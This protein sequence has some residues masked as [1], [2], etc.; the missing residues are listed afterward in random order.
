VPTSPQEAG[1]SR[2]WR[3]ITL[4]LLSFLA[5]AARAADDDDAS[6]STAVGMNGAALPRLQ[7]ANGVLYLEVSLNGQSTHNLVSF[8]DRAGHLLVQQRDLTALGIEPTAANLHLAAVAPEV[9]PGHGSAATEGD[10]MLDLNKM[11]GVRYQLDRSHQTID[12][13]VSDEQRTPYALGGHS[14]TV[15]PARSGTGVVFNYDVLAQTSALDGPA[16]ASLSM[17]SEQ[18]LFT[19]IGVLSNFGLATWNGQSQLSGT[20]NH[21]TRE[22]TTFE[23]QN[24]ASLQTADLGDVVSGALGWTRSV[25]LGGFQVRSDYSLDP[26]MIT[27]PVPRFNGSAALPSTV[28]LYVNNVRQYSGSVPGGPFVV[29]GGLGITGAGTATVVVHD[30]FGR[31]VSTTMPIYVDNRLLAPGLN[32]YSVESGVLRFNYGLESFGYEGPPA[33]SGTFRRGLSDVV[34]IESHGE[35]TSRLVDGGGGALFRLGSSGVLHVAAAGSTSEGHGGSQYL[36]G[37]Q[38]ILP[39]FSFTAQSI[40]ATSGYRDLATFG[41]TPAPRALDQVTAS[42]VTGRDSTLGASYVHLSDSVQRNS[43]IVALYYSN[44]LSHRANAFVNVSDDLA[45]SHSAALFVGFSYDM[46]RRVSSAL[47]F[48]MNNGRATYGASAVRNVDYGGGLEWTLQANRNVGQT[49]GAGRVGYLGEYGEISGIAQNVAGHTQLSIEDVGGLVFMDGTFEASRRV[50]D[51]FALVSTGGVA[52]VPVLHENRP[53]GTT[54]SGGHF[55]VPDL[56]P[57]THNSLSIDSL[58]LA[59][60]VSVPM[61]SM[62]VTPRGNSGVLADFHIGHYQAASITLVNS[63][64]KPLPAGTVAHVA[65]SG[66]DFVVGYDGLA[67]IEE[68]RPENHLQVRTPEAQCSAQFSFNP[69]ASTALAN[70]GKVVC[71]PAGAHPI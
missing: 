15:P 9:P 50:G 27:F 35:V 38:V 54:D 49:S 32:S 26:Q 68:L 13:Q 69:T 67:F 28:D 40:R 65:E 10:R 36:L 19:P 61:A 16:R 52:G 59:A 2:A 23:Y 58:T 62:D 18:R 46:E 57:Y 60:N 45:A 25:R 34:T 6:S 41:G 21:Y 71:R 47:D 37:Y 39:V 70:L 7:T 66:R 1:K 12:L 11:Q 44:R 29:N 4:A 55:L 48:G 8:I 53:I 20:N 42:V 24:P 17:F 64:G 31:N 3:A 5:Q 30:E 43:S 33:F 56:N 22:T 51:G 14:R 63:D